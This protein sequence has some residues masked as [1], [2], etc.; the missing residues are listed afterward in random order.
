MAGRNAAAL[1]LNRPPRVPPR[2]TAMGALAYYVSH[3]DPRHY[4]PTNITFGIMQPLGTASDRRKKADRKLA[5]AER[6]LDD[7]SRWIDEDDLA[8]LA[9]SEPSSTRVER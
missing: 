8:G 4:Q 2:T 9:L 7:L 3:A 5:Y 1:V 6:A